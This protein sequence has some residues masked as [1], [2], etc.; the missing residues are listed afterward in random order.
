MNKRHELMV[1]LY[2][3][4]LESRGDSLYPHY[5]DKIGFSEGGIG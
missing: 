3:H 2:C 5:L 4:Q 1:L